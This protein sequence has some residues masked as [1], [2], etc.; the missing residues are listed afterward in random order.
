MFNETNKYFKECRF[1]KIKPQLNIGSLKQILKSKKDMIINESKMNINSKDI[2]INSHILDYAINNALNRYKSCLTNL[3]KGNIKYF[4][5]RYLKL[6][7]PNK[8]LI[9][10]KEAFTGE[11]FCTRILGKMKCEINNYEFRR[12]LIS[13]SIIKLENNEVTLFIKMLVKDRGKE[14]KYED[15]TNIISIDPGIRTFITGYS[16]E[17]T[18]KIG[19]NLYETVKKDLE[20]IDK[21]NTFKVNHSLKNKIKRLYE[22]IKNRVN[23]LHW[24]IIDNLTENYQTIIIGNLSTKKIGEGKIN[25]MVKRVGNMMSLFKFKEKLKYRCKYTNTTYMEINE[26]YTSKCCCRCGNY[27]KELKGEKIYE[28]KKCGLKIDR[29]MNGAINIGILS[30]E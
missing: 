24:K 11:G 22:R 4:R 19:T 23:D 14:D 5:L 17:K 1:N 13:T 9:L 28:C 15:K 10:E 25:E 21:I 12:D 20:K 7:R 3:R 26:S 18:V 6:N 30:Y 27:K 16:N 29:D 2:Q 8:I